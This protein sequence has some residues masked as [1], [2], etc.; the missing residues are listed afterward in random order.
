MQEARKKLVLV[1]PFARRWRARAAERAAARR[2][3]GVV[4]SV[5]DDDGWQVL[6]RRR[7]LATPSL[8]SI[9]NV[10]ASDERQQSRR[11]P[12]AGLSLTRPIDFF[13]RPDEPSANSPCLQ[14]SRDEPRRKT[15]GSAPR[16]HLGDTFLAPQRR[17]PI[18]E[19]PQ[20]MQSAVDVAGAALPV[21]R[22]S[23]SLALGGLSR[24]SS[25]PKPRIPSL[26]FD[27]DDGGPSAPAQPSWQSSQAAG[28]EQRG[29]PQPR[30]QPGVPH[31]PSSSRDT[32]SDVR[33]RGAEGAAEGVPN[34]FV[35]NAR[36]HLRQVDHPTAGWAFASAEKE[37]ARAQVALAAAENWSQLDGV[38]LSHPPLFGATPTAPP[39]RERNVARNEDVMSAVAAEMADMEGALRDFQVA[40]LPSV[41]FIT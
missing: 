27:D 12:W 28:G 29:P 38:A 23:H 11:P 40:C 33:W 10:A 4:G 16:P 2:E 39:L 7:R 17:W 41:S 18:N 5:K 8:S 21:W 24:P 9:I 14:T 37:Q 3:G 26:L 25:R 36:M 13:A 20:R 1:E 30:A 6:M 31:A 35:L 22:A 32:S 15:A 19:S 34:Q